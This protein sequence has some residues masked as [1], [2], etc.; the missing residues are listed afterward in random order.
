MVRL[1]NSYSYRVPESKTRKT[2]KSTYTPPQA[3]SAKNLPPSP[4]W[5]G[6]TIL[7]LFAVAI[8][9][10]IGYTLGP[11]PGQGALGSWNYVVVIGA[12]LGAVALLTRWR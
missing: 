12:F 8:V 4:P 7:V 3:T 2:T 5:V 11:I 10:L 1:G 6:A 9:W